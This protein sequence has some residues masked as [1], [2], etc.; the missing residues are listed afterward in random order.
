MSFAPPCSPWV[1][2]RYASADRGVMPRRIG[3]APRHGAEHVSW[4]AD[5]TAEHRPQTLGAP[6]MGAPWMGA[7]WMGAPWTD[8]LAGPHG[9]DPGDFV[10]GEREAEQVDV[11]GDPVRVRRLRDE[12][13][14]VL[15]VPAEHHLGR[16]D[17][18]G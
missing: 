18:I 11:G 9:V 2:R 12:G 15:D 3:G 5:D 16:R 4:R 7:P 6:W 17:E 13:N 10:G 1:R 14:A 8:R